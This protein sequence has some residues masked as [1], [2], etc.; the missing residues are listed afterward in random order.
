MQVEGVAEP[1]HADTD[2]VGIP[3][4][5]RI[6]A[7]R[8]LRTLTQRE[9]VDRMRRPVTTAAL[10][11]IEAGKV[12]PTA[13]T[14]RD[15]ADALEVPLGFFSA[16]WSNVPAGEVFD[17][18][19][20]FRDLAATPARQRKRAGALALILSDLVAALDSRVR[21]PE[22]SVPSFPVSPTAG[23]DEIEQTAE[24]LRGEWNLGDEPV[25]HVVREIERHGI[26]CARLF[27]DTK[28]VDAFSVRF[29]VRPLILLT[30]DKSNYVRSRFDAAHELGH[31]IMHENTDPND[32][33]IEKQ[34]HD[35][36]SSLLL[37]A[38]IAIRELPRRIDNFGWAKLAQMKR[39]WGISMSALLFRA[40][41]LN[42][43]QADA[44]QNAMKY[45]SARGWR[46]V[47]PGDRE[48]GRPEAPM[49]VEHAIKKIEHEY[50]LSAEDIVRSADLPLLDTLILIKAASDRR[51]ALDF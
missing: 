4:P 3:H 36:A 49:L 31:L 27:L 45:M 47:E 17:R 46:T 48:M 7:A 11:Q 14:L 34:A 26:P 18:V 33:S 21:L 30:N 28:L 6:R 1:V 10:S 12:R 23:H 29:S 16:N 9:T 2:V 44:Y 42:V 22:V 8:D 24:A 39:E 5:A 20:Y 15:L 50:E 19:P 25:A 37:P 13:D 51:P 38:D 40:R 32:R 43:L 41:A 35:F